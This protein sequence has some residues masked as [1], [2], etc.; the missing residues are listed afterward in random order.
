VDRLPVVLAADEAY[1]KQL[2][3]VLRSLADAAGSTGYTAF[4]LQ[5]HFGRELRARVE[6]SCD[7]RVTVTWLDVPEHLVDGVERT[8]RVPRTSAFRIL[9][10]TLL[11]TGPSRVVYLDCDVV[12]RKPPDALWSLD[13]DG[14]PVA[15]VRDA[16]FPVAC[17][18]IPWRRAGI[19]PSA[20]YFNAG[21]LV[22]EV[23]HWRTL[24]V[25]TRGMA[26]LREGRLRY[27]DQSA[28]N[29]LFANEWRPLSPEWNLQTHHLSE[30]SRAWGFEDRDALDR[31]I[32]DPAIIHLSGTDRPWEVG[33]LHPHRD[34][35][36][37]ALDRT[38]WW[39]WRPRRQW[40]A[41]ASRRVRRAGAALLGRRLD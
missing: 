6:A 20:A 21:V 33:S 5:S 41:G 18:E 3:V 2:A 37:A 11:P 16:Y 30:R 23:D 24:D 8:A 14:A 10:P 13:L 40:G 28:L 7:E 36:F 4:V 29:I 27:F 15:A 1:A 12:V 26:L 9:A 25:A 17:M 22:I 38:P 31:A 39:G 32:A 19:D 34:A 35:W